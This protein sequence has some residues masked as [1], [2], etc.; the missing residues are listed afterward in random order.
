MSAAT[1]FGLHWPIIRDCKIAKKLL[2]RFI[3]YS[4]SGE[5]K[6]L[7]LKLEMIK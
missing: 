2:N 5:D 4:T 1:C 7:F 6:I 3:T